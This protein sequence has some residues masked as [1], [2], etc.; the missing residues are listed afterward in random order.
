MGLRV[1][2]IFTNMSSCAHILYLIK[3]VTCP[4]HFDLVWLHSS[5]LS[6]QV[7]VNVLWS[8]AQNT[9]TMY[10]AGGWDIRTEV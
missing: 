5:Q 9:C 3:I 8:T 1:D 2:A 6:G 7:N 4:K 10:I